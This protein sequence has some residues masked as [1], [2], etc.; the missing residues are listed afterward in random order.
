MAEF[1]W[2]NQKEEAAQLLSDG[3]LT[4]EAIGLKVGVHR[5]TIA[6]WN[7][8]PEFS[9]RVEELNEEFRR[10]TA[11]LAIARREKRVNALNQRWLAMQRV[12]DERADDPSMTDVPGGRTGLIVQD[13]KTVGVGDNAVARA[14]YS[15]DT[16]L[17]KM[18]LDHEK[19]AAQELGQWVEKGSQELSGP[20]GGAIPFG[21]M[22]DKVYGNK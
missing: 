14:T 8:L 19:Q 10:S 15:V 13:W 11:H 17:L 1:V 5:V 4:H 6:K 18:I 22:V 20:N 12:I 21:E 16:G 7:S 2:T 3:R 9:A